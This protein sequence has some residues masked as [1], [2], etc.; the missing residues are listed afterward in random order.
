M[1]RILLNYHFLHPISSFFPLLLFLMVTYYK[2][3]ER[4]WII[5][6]FSDSPYLNCIED[7]RA[8]CLVSSFGLCHMYCPYPH[9]IQIHNTYA[10]HK[11]INNAF[12]VFSF[13][14]FF[15][16]ITLLKKTEN[17][18]VPDAYFSHFR[19]HSCNHHCEKFCKFKR[20]DF[21]FTWLPKWPMA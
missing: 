1:G 19:Q 11:F 10:L 6:I 13:L 14:R 16:A 2:I 4:N 18:N 9:V 7:A 8:W 20:C 15:L 5:L 21:S 3:L 17:I 12:A